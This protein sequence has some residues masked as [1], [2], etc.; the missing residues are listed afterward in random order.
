MKESPERKQKRL[1][2]VNKR[3]S[4]KR[5]KEIKFRREP[6]EDFLLGRFQINNSVSSQSAASSGP[7]KERQQLNPLDKPDTPPDR[8]KKEN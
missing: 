5:A 6:G 1:T 7:E 2:Q 3:K 8:K 4:G